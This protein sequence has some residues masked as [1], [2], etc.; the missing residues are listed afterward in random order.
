MRLF[1]ILLLATSVFFLLLLAPYPFL[2][3][4]EFIRWQ[5]SRPDFPPSFRFTPQEREEFSIAS[6]RYLITSKGLDYLRSLADEKGPIYNERELRHMADVKR[7]ATGALVILRLSLAL[8]ISLAIAFWLKGWRRE[9]AFG[10]LGGV[11]ALIG[12]GLAVGITATASFDLFF[13]L[14]HRL[15]FE[16]DSWLFPYTD[17][18]IQLYPLPFWVTATKCWLAISGTATFVTG[19]ISLILYR[20]SHSAGQSGEL[21]GEN[22]G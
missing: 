1:L 9:L 11:L 22:Q 19:I 5:Y 12:L 4:P 8:A 17:S 10:L 15:L 6:L 16:G 21:R 7:V 18:L 2:A 14:F 13:T 3:R 20:F